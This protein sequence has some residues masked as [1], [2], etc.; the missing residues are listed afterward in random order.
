[1]E[2]FDKIKEMRTAAL[3]SGDKFLHGVLTLVYSDAE[4]VGKD[5]QREVTDDDVQKVVKKHLD[6]VVETLGYIKGKVEADVEALKVREKAILEG[7]RPAQL[8]EEVLGKI[9]AELNATKLGEYMKHLKD[10]FPNQYDGN[11]AKKV[12]EAFKG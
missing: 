9:L 8:T 1:M 10:N 7:L 5:A 12:F 2:L 6:G 11:L 3:K 4:K